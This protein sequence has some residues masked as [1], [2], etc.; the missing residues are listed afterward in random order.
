MGD[1]GE[2]KPG[3]APGL[4]YAS[5]SFVLNRMINFAGGQTFTVA[6]ATTLA[7][8]G[9]HGY[10][11]GDWVL[12]TNSGGALPS[13]LVD[14]RNGATAP[15][16]YYVLSSGLTSTQFQLATTAGGS[17]ISVSGGSGTQTVVNPPIANCDAIVHAPY[18]DAAFAQSE[19]NAADYPNGKSAGGWADQVWNYNSGSTTTAFNWIHDEFINVSQDE[20][21]F[22]NRHP[23]E[24][25]PG[26]VYPQLDWHSQYVFM[27]T[28][29]I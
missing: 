15:T 10:V 18:Y 12:V 22:P 26:H 8:S 2:G 28:T 4:T 20:G 6:N 23:I 9:A 3:S 29:R 21:H 11:A 24:R 17:A 16:I 7:T 25:Y 27:R 14:S 1:A 19:G 13:P 5:S